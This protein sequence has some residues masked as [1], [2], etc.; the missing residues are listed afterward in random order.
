M[1]IAGLTR[2]DI[3]W[4][5]GA[6]ARHGSAFGEVHVRAVKRIIAYLYHTRFHGLVYRSKA[7]IPENSPLRRVQDAVLFE[8]G[9]PPIMTK[10]GE[11]RL[12]SD[13]Y[14]IFCDADFAGDTTRR[15]TCGIITFLNCGP[16]SWT[17]RLMK[18]QALSTTESEIYAATEAIKDAAYLK[19]HLSALRVRE[20]VAIPVHED[21]SACVTMGVSYLKTYNKARHYVT[22]LNFLQERVH[23]KTVQLV[24]TPTK[25]QIA[26]VMTKPLSG[27]DFNRFRDI[28][29]KNVR[30]VILPVEIQI[31]SN[32]A[33]VFPANAGFYE[34]SE[35]FSL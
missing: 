23:D 8:S 31:T 5:T 6:V 10:D 2:P 11:T 20:N 15:S 22:R 17:S 4:A 14:Q 35:A 18:L 24:P 3:A 32:F 7:S 25:E 1:H 26:D 33:H 34:R 19:A 29:V 30:Q 27:N 9:R 13:P 16:I 28:I 12:Q 21:N